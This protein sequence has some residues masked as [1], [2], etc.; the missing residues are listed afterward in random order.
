M[1]YWVA[2]GL[3]VHWRVTARGEVAVAVRLVGFP[4]V[5]SKDEYGSRSNP[6][7]VTGVLP[8]PGVIQLHGGRRL[9]RAVLLVEDE[10]VVVVAG[11]GDGG[12]GG[13]GRRV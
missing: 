3:P 2:R 9:S 6:G 12:M 4:G 5:Y 8:P 10:I 11:E 1:S 13:A 7:T